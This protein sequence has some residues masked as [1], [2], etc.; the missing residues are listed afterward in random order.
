MAPTDRRRRSSATRGPSV[1]ELA[2][3]RLGERGR[4]PPPRPW[5][6]YLFSRRSDG[7]FTATQL[8]LPPVGSLDAR[9]ELGRGWALGPPEPMPD[10]PCLATGVGWLHDQPAR[11]LGA[12]GASGRWGQIEPV[13]S[14]QGPTMSFRRC[15]LGN[16]ESP[17]ACERR[18][19]LRD[20][21]LRTV[22]YGV[23]FVPSR[24]GSCKAEAGGQGRS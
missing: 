19:R 20:P 4:S 10:V 11:V 8:P 23:Q 17:S 1:G 14:S 13:V 24:A 18:N 7:L 2:T 3:G 6:S 15:G 21:K 5:C 16:G 12:T 22:S 9:R